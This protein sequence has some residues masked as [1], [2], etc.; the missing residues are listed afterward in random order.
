MHQFGLR[1]KNAHKILGESS[2]EDIIETSELSKG[3]RIC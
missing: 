3:T 1:S 2:S